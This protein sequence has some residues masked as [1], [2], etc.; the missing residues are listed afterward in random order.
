MIGAAA[1]AVALA[2]AGAHAQPARLSL[3]AS[4]THVRLVPGGRQLVHVT[5]PGGRPLV[6]E[7]RIAGYALDLLGRPRITRPGDAAPW[8]AVTPSRITV[9]RSGA[10]FTVTA[11]RPLHARPGDHTAVVLLSALVPSARGV[12]VRMRIG[13]TL[14]MRIAGRVVHRVTV[15]GARLRRAGSSRSLELALANR[16]NV[17]ESIGG[18]RLRVAILRRNRVVARLGIA[19]RE[20]LPGTRGLVRLRLGADRHGPAVVQVKLQRAARSGWVERR[21]RLRL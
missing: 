6:V 16:G 10:E 12:V 13:L 5:T 9:G 4:P 20:L 2:A 1:L 11:R 3:A 19:R 18:G 15:L 7:A 17:T 8:I 14:V 21:F